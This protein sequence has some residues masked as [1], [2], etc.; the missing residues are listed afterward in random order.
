MQAVLIVPGTERTSRAGL[1]RYSSTE[2]DADGTL[3]AV[4]RKGDVDLATLVAPSLIIKP[5]MRMN[6]PDAAAVFRSRRF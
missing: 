5:P 6:S 1:T 4:D 2:A 3:L